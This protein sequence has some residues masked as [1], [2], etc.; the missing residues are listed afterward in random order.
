M[1]PGDLQ[2]MKNEMPTMAII[3]LTVV[4]ETQ[5][6]A[7]KGSGS[8]CVLLISENVLKVLFKNGRVFF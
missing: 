2:S 7:T 5:N 8:T 3:S 1:G 6:N 4:E